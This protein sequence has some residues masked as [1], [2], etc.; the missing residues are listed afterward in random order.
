MIEIVKKNTKSNTKPHYL[1]EYEYMIGDADGQTSEVVELSLDNPH[2]EKYCRLLN[3]LK[4]IKGHWGVVLSSDRIKKSLR[5]KQITQDE[6]DFLMCTMF[7][8]YRE[9]VDS[10]K[11]EDNFLDEFWEGVKSDA[12]YSFLIFEG[13]I[14]T[15]VDEFGEK[16]KTKFVK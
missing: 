7:E 9:E 3:K 2:I 15:Y 11:D 14:L 10:L 6:Y 1:L 13:V 5:E 12:E 4:P 8:C 16:F